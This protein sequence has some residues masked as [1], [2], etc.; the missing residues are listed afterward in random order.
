MVCWGWFLLNIAIAACALSF[1]A[2]FWLLYADTTISNVVQP[3]QVSNAIS[4][5]FSEGLFATCKGTSS[6][7]SCEWFWQ[8][9]FEWEKGRTSWQQAAQGLF[10]AGL[11]FLTVVLAIGAFHICCCC[12]KESFSIGTTLGSLTI[13]GI[14]L[15]AASL[16]VYGGYN[17]N[18]GVNFSS[19]STTKFYWGFFVGIFGCVLALVSVILFFCAGCRNRD[20]TGYQMTRVV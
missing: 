17:G 12:C 8:D 10:A 11:I 5:R 18:Q 20:H 2:P 14:M 16:G 6:S 3:G 9:N 7:L 19:E 15:V 4:K 13:F 1:V